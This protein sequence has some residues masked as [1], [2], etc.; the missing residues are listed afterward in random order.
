MQIIARCRNCDEELDLFLRPMIVE[1]GTILVLS[2]SLCSKCAEAIEDEAR[3]RAYSE[4]V[5]RS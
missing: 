3:T 2:V 4:K 5:R 1:G